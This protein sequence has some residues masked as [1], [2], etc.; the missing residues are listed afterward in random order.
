MGAVGDDDGRGP[1]GAAGI[2][3]V[4]VELPSASVVPPLVMVA[5]FPPILMRSAA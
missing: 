5:A 1:F 2:V 4:T 3:K